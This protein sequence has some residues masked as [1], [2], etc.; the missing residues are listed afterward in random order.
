MLINAFALLLM[1][2]AVACTGVELV[3]LAFIFA[4]AGAG[5]IFGYDLWFTSGVPLVL[6]VSSFAVTAA[7]GSLLWTRWQRGNAKPDP[8]PGKSAPG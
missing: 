6:S 2:L 3:F 7:L 1:G 5:K 4:L 8:N